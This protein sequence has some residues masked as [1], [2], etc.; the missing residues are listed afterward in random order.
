MALGDGVKIRVYIIARISEEAHLWNKKIASALDS[1]FE[2][3]LPQDHNPFNR[4]HESFPKSVFD[5]DMAAIKRSN[6]GLMLPEYGADC[7]FEAGWYSN[8]G[9]PLVVFVDTQLEW[10]RDWM[11]KGGID[12]VV[13]TSKF[14]FESLKADPILRHKQILLIESLERL[15]DALAKICGENNG[16]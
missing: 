7:A 12:C 4:K 9:K 11:V 6:V 14:A 3:F 5:I 13:T 10:L 2:I 8:S 15:G 16:W 1:R